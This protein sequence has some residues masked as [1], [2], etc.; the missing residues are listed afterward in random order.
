VAPALVE[1][2]VRSRG[3]DA[4]DCTATMV[5]LMT[6]SWLSFDDREQ[7]R[8]H[9]DADEGNTAA[10]PS[11][12]CSRATLCSSRLLCVDEGGSGGCFARAYP[13]GGAV[14]VRVDSQG[15]LGSRFC[16]RPFRLGRPT[17]R[18]GRVVRIRQVSRE[19]VLAG[20]GLTLRGLCFGASPSE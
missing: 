15:A 20:L 1:I 3:G 17:G 10:P 7:R 5:S 9:V 8:S 13:G 2:L 11:I 18:D 14:Q 4:R 6:A 16:R 19:T 12:H